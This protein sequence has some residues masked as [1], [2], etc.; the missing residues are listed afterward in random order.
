M[1]Y[2]FFPT[3]SSDIQKKLAGAKWPEEKIKDAINVHQYLL[4]KSPTPVNFDLKE[5]GKVN[6]TRSL[7]GDFKIADIV[8]G[9]NITQFKLKF[10]NGS[11][12]NRGA[13]NK[14]NKF[15]TDFANAID[16]WWAGK[17]GWD[18]D[19]SVAKAIEGLNVTYNLTKSKTF[20]AAVL[21][22]E[23][24]R[25]PIVFGSKIVLANPKGEGY[26][27]GPSVTDIT[28]KTDFDPIYLSLKLG[29]T[30]TFFNVGVKKILTKTEIESGNITNT[31]GLKL[32]KLLGIDPKR[33]C[34][35]FNGDKGA[36]GKEKV[37]APTALNELL[38]S[39]IGYNYHIIHKFPGKVL[40]KKMDKSAMKTAGKIK[41]GLI[42][43]YGGKGGTAKRVNI[44]CESKTYSFQLNIR[45]TQ[46][47]DGYP[48]R[49][50]CDFKYA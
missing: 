23:N 4:R 11:A 50:M 12:G 37:S 31:D 7:Q 24:T 45:D 1:A 22:G 2:D 8:K 28:L 46:G 6:V 29:S 47:T 36:G 16:N 34:A 42:I 14:G 41:G 35:V 44:Q 5:K 19:K 27:V 38:M 25:R 3:S 13:N 30:T 21:G 40:S 9:A 18:K 20:D 48:T 17:E 10:G 32:L 43:E 26:D 33:F 49:L 39:G 15:E